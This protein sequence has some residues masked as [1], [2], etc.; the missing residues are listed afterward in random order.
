MIIEK[1]KNANRLAALKQ[2]DQQNNTLVYEVMAERISTR[3]ERQ[4][5]SDI[6]N[7]PYLMQKYAGGVHISKIIPSTNGLDI[8]YAKVFGSKGYELAQPTWDLVIKSSEGHYHDR[9]GSKEIG[10]QEVKDFVE[11]KAKTEMKKKDIALIKQGNIIG[12][13]KIDNND[14][15]LYSEKKLFRHSAVSNILWQVNVPPT[16][17]IIDVATLDSLVIMVTESY[18]GFRDGELY[19]PENSAQVWAFI[20]PQV[21]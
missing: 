6:Y 3:G 12:S 2:I 9:L 17:R 18:Q 10:A 21:P 20:S 5:P 8:L 7:I 4:E 14:F 16:Y 19:F 1:I 11:L 13:V 15:L